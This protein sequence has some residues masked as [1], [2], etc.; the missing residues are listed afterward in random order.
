MIEDEIGG[1]PDEFDELVVG[2]RVEA[3]RTKARQY[4]LSGLALGAH[5]AGFARGGVAGPTQ[6]T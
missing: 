3:G 5:I 1:V 2:L 6:I 4:Q